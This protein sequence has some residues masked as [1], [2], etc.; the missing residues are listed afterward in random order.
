[1]NGKGKMLFAIGLG[2]WFDVGLGVHRSKLGTIYF[3]DDYT[4]Q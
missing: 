2:G 1:M 3:A 4:K